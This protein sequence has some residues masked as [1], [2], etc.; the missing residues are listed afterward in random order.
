M[1]NNHHLLSLPRNGVSGI[2]RI[3]CVIDDKAYIGSSVSIRQR[4]RLHKYNLKNGKHH[5]PHLQ[6]AWVKYGEENFVVEVVKLV[7]KEFLLAEEQYYIDTEC[8]EYNVCKVAGSNYGVPSPKKGVEQEISNEVRFRMGSGWRGKSLTDETKQLMSET[9]KG[10]KKSPEWKSKIAESVKKK[11]Q[12]PTDAMIAGR[13]R[14]AQGNSEWRWVTN[15]EM[16][17]RVHQ[18]ELEN[19]EAGFYR[20]R[21]VKR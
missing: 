17:K 10:R 12:E 4:W 7:D 8:P 18:S 11:H 19:L 14:T 21:T 6:N 20:G 13:S 9:R 5:S 15:G 16:N 3:R 2:Y 1:T